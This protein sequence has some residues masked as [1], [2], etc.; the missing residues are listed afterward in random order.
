MA[1]YDVLLL[2]L[3]LCESGFSQAECVKKSY[4]CSFQYNN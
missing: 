2:P 4:Y 1:G 3:M